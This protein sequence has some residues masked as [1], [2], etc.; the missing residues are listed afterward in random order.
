MVNVLWV[1]FLVPNVFKAFA[2][3]TN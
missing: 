3:R 1:Y 2:F